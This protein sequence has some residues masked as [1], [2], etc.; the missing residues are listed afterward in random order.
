MREQPALGALGAVL[1]VRARSLPRCVTVAPTSELPRELNGYSMHQGFFFYVPQKCQHFPSVGSLQ[2]GGPCANQLSSK[3]GLHST[4]VA[5][6]SS[7]QGPPPTVTASP[8]G[9]STTLEYWVTRPCSLRSASDHPLHFS[10]AP[11]IGES[12]EVLNRKGRV[13]TGAGVGTSGPGT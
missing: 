8:R 10:G 3:T 2:S 4:G 5:A 6:T 1:R 9:V 12:E 7:S 11:S 13:P